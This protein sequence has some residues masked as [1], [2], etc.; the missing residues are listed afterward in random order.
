[1]N[2][3]ILPGLEKSNSED[4]LGKMAIFASLVMPEAMKNAGAIRTLLAIILSYLSLPL[5]IFMRLD[6]GERT[7]SP[8]RVFN[9]LLVLQSFWFVTSVVSDLIGRAISASS[10]LGGVSTSSGGVGVP[11]FFQA[12]FLLASACHLWRISYRRRKGIRVHSFSAGY[13]LIEAVGWLDWANSLL[14]RITLL[15]RWKI[16]FRLTRWHLYLYFE[17]LIGALVAHVLQVH[18]P[19]TS[20]W[21]WIASTSLFIRNHLMA[22]QQRAILLDYFDSQLDAE[23]IRRAADQAPPTETAGIMVLPGF[24]EVFAHAEALDI[25]D[26]VRKTFSSE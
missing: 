17:P 8:L 22:A 4:E 6:H 15:G 11:S 23:F 13:S 1:M 12:A 16:P 14:G 20:V 18:D 21:L 25:A 5:E 10:L 24:A 7:L 26:R 2:N 3:P 19:I 9:A